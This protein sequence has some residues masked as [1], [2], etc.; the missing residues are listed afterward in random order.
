[1]EQKILDK[2]LSVENMKKVNGDVWLRHRNGYGQLG[3]E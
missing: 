3:K 2:P 1:M